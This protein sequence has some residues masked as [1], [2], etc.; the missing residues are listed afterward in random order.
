MT[1][2]F[3]YCCAQKLVLK[4]DLDDCKKQKAMATVSGISGTDRTAE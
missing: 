4:V 2:E 1:L 3:F